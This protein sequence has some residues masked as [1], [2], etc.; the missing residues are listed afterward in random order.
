MRKWVPSAVVVNEL[1]TLFHRN[2]YV[3]LPNLDR[4]AAT[5]RAYKKGYEVRLVADT[6]EELRYIQHLLRLAGFE[7]GQPFG[8]APR[9]RQPLYGRA[10]VERFLELVGPPPEAETNT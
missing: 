4:R 6:R 1:A 3:R 8:K 10:V 9:L 7:P 2:G 5:P